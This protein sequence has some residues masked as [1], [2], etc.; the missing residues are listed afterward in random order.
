LGPSASYTRQR[1]STKESERDRY[2]WVRKDEKQACHLAVSRLCRWAVLAKPPLSDFVA[3]EEE[4]RTG[5]ANATLLA[6]VAAVACIMFEGTHSCTRGNSSVESRKS[7][8]RYCC[9]PFALNYTSRYF[10]L[11]D[12]SPFCC[13]VGC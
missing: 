1:L 11:P 2:R 4:D 10:P 6:A 13:V 8:T 9:I 12:L 3:A 5:C 7:L